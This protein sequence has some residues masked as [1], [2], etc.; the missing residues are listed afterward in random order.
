MAKDQNKPIV[1][2][3]SESHGEVVFIGDTTRDKG[4]LIPDNEIM[5]YPDIPDVT[6]EFAARLRFG[7]TFE[8]MEFLAQQKLTLTQRMAD[9]HTDMQMI[10]RELAST[11]ER[12]E[13]RALD[14]IGRMR[15]ADEGRFGIKL[16]SLN[17]ALVEVHRELATVKHGAKHMVTKNKRLKKKEKYAHG[18]LAEAERHISELE[19]QLCAQP[20]ANLPQAASTPLEE[21]RK[22]EAALTKTQKAAE[23]AKTEIGWF[24]DEL[25]QSLDRETN[26]RAQAH[27]AVKDAQEKL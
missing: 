11:A 5:S 2:L 23:T 17:T 22:L 1:T 15:N 6:H 26:V 14:K 19:A 8:L 21:L 12:T 27:K 16:T 24:R 13:G 4:P 3:I 18:Q 20:V 9:E 25:W 7:T 10:Q